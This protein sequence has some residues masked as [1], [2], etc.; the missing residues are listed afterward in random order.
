MG[1]TPP[2]GQTVA[3]INE[4]P[5]AVTSHCATPPKTATPDPVRGAPRHDDEV[6][7]ADEAI[8]ALRFNSGLS[9]AGLLIGGISI[10]LIALSYSDW[11]GKFK[12]SRSAEIGTATVKNDP[13]TSRSFSSSSPDTNSLS[14][15]TDGQQNRSQ[16]QSEN[17]SNGGRT[18]MIE[19]QGGPPRTPSREVTPS[20]RAG[21]DAIVGVGVKAM[22]CRNIQLDVAG[23]AVFV[24][25]TDVDPISEE[26]CEALLTRMIEKRELTCTLASAREYKCVLTEG[27]RDVAETLAQMKVTKSSSDNTAANIS[28]KDRATIISAYKSMASYYASGDYNRVSSFW[29]QTAPI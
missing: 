3:A 14:A 22:D 21:T 19:P 10:V 7:S 17:S 29:I 12:A 11:V 28:E 23:T 13:P 6:S 15:Q 4:A 25:L 26:Q 8:S 2:R 5:S 20:S 9:F 24:K 16:R 18:A 1:Q 27:G